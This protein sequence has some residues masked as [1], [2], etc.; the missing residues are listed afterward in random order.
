MFS[1]IYVHR[2]PKPMC[3][4]LVLNVNTAKHTTNT[5]IVNYAQT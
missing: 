5:T 4:P 2:Q 3:S 1:H